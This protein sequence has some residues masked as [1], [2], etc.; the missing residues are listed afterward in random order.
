[1]ASPIARLLPALLVLLAACSGPRAAGPPPAEPPEE[2]PTPAIRLSDYEDFDAAPYREPAPQAADEVQHDV[3]ERLMG[4]RASAGSATTVQ[5]FRVQVYSTIDKSA[6]VNTEEEVKSWL[7]TQQGLP[8]GLGGSPVYTVYLQPY[9]RVR[10]G[11]FRSQAEADRAR[12][13]L[14]RRFPDAFIVRDTVTITR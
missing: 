8:S 11:N 1:M 6:A 2:V 4:G 12:A 9:Y 3:P 5:G 13:F 14:A 7:T 10:I